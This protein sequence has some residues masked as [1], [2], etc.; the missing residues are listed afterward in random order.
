MAIS[1]R[2]PRILESPISTDFYGN[3][4]VHERELPPEIDGLRKWE[5]SEFNY[6]RELPYDAWASGMHL[7]AFEPHED[8]DPVCLYD[9]WGNIVRQWENMPSFAEL[10]EITTSTQPTRGR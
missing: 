4:I 5:Y 9:R 8:A 2:A 10:C 6:D 3:P 7:V 1:I